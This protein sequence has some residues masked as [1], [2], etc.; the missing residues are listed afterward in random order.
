[1]A[2]RPSASSNLL[3]AAWRDGRGHVTGGVCAHESLGGRARRMWSI[4]RC[5]GT[6]SFESSLAHALCLPAQGGRRR[7]ER[8]GRKSA[9]AR[10][11]RNENDLEMTSL[12]STTTTATTSNVKDTGT[13]TRTRTTMQEPSTSSVTHPDSSPMTSSAVTTSTS[14]SSSYSSSST[15]FS[16]SSTESLP[17]YDTAL[18]MAAIADTQC[19]ITT[20]RNSTRTAGGI[21]VAVA[22]ARSPRKRRPVAKDDDDGSRGDT[23]SVETAS[24][25][26]SD[27]ADTPR[28]QPS[29][30]STIVPSK[31]PC[32]IVEDRETSL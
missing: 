22:T 19:L 7:K 30:T 5:T 25:Y 18:N 10:D 17:S 2:V 14:Y 8:I 13:R 31:I 11:L 3:G 12:V 28:H 16:T 32:R 29:S 20:R 21:Q 9:A 4:R 26:V 23:D 24:T 6:G 27:Q 15:S 1:M